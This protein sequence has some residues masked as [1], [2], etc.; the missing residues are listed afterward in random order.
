MVRTV[1]V[2]PVRAVLSPK[3]RPAVTT[4]AENRSGTSPVPATAW[5]NAGDSNS[6]FPDVANF[7]KGAW[8][9][10]GEIKSEASTLGQG[11]IGMAV[12]ELTEVGREVSSFS[13]DVVSDL[14]ELRD[15][16]M[17]TPEQFRELSRSLSMDV[18][19][20]FRRM[21]PTTLDCTSGW[22]NVGQ[23]PQ[24][25]H[26]A[27]S[28]Q[29]TEKPMCG[30]EAASPQ[31]VV[32]L[33]TDLSAVLNDAVHYAKD[34]FIDIDEEIAALHRSLLEVSADQHVTWPEGTI[35]NELLWAPPMVPFPEGAAA[36]WSQSSSSHV[37]ESPSPP[38]GHH[39]KSLATPHSWENET[40]QP[41]C[42]PVS[43]STHVVL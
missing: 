37:G 27:L 29:C 13:M 8:H 22:G 38:R 23:Y 41:V 25:R 30:S 43:Q 6:W 18:P 19:D 20:D 35:K 31:S 34:P 11:I 16:S 15:I 3:P 4:K 2:A 28:P 36:S 40:L 12:Q 1:Q 26:V 5:Y 17:D 32:T 21:L 9:D 39:I 7:F 14:K 42:F 33:E 24:C 10:F